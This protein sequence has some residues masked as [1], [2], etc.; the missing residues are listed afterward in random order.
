MLQILNVT[1]K[2]HPYTYI[3]IEKTKTGGA[4][5]SESFICFLFKYFYFFYYNYT[6][7]SFTNL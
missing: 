1:N 5:Y 7:F 4:Y 3:H 6:M 2:K